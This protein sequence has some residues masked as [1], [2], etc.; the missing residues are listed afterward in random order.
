MTIT[1]RNATRSELPEIIRLLADDQIGVTR[2]KY[3]EPLLPAYYAAFDAIHADNNCRLI[4]AELENKI[5]GTFQITFIRYLTFQGGKRAIIEE[6]RIDK[7]MRNKGFGKMMMEWAI[8]LA[9]ENA[10]HLVQLTSNKQR[11]QAI[12]FYKRLGFVASHEGLKLY[13]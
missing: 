13:V 1:F 6:V 7:S 10:C 5:I 11:T 12:E 2:E 4:V 9:K 3:E 8:Q